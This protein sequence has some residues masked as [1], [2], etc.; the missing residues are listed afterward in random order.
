MPD[1]TFN[2]ENIVDTVRE[3]I[4]VLSADLKVQRANRSFYRTFQVAPQDTENRLV[5]ELGNGQWDIPALRKLLEEILPQNTAFEDF[6]VAHDFPDIGRKVMLLNARRIHRDGH[7]PEAILLA[8]EDITERRK[9][10]AALAAQ[11]EWLRVTLRSIGDAVIATDTEGRVTLLNSVAEQLTGWTT[12]E[13]LGLPLESVF[14]IVN[15]ETRRTVENPVTRA[16]REGNVVG[17]ANH[18]LLVRKDGT[19][20][21]IDD[22]AAPIRDASG[23]VIGVVLVFRDITERRKAER[24]VQ[25]ALEYAQNIVETVRESML[26]LDGVSGRPKPATYGRLKTSHFEEEPIRHLHSPVVL[27]HGEG[28]HGESSHNG[29]RRLHLHPA[30][31]PLVATA[32]CPRTGHRPPDRGPLPAATKTR[33]GTIGSGTEAEEAKPATAPIGSGTEAEEAKPATAPIGSTEVGEQA[34]PAMAP[35]GFTEVGEQAK[36]ATAPSAQ[37]RTGPFQPPQLFRPAAQ[38]K[39]VSVNPFAKSFWPSW[40]WVC[41]RKGSTRT[42]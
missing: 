24:A 15:E 27:T 28:N 6:E 4:L 35:I 31:A 25:D 41:P 16:L 37:T 23:G 12:P 34:K 21:S 36:P 7:H 26:V 22:S 40:N 3:P 1:Q 33:H 30:P 20:R 5:Y 32:Y 17:L 14:Q 9:L 42:W 18:T 13:A 2:A 38:D 39:P 29:S 8:I 11:Q 10:E 19:E